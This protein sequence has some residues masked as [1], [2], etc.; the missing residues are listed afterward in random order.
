[1]RPSITRARPG[2]GLL[3]HHVRVAVGHRRPDRQPAEPGSRPVRAVGG[4]LPAHRGGVLIVIFLT[5][6]GRR[7][8]S[9]G[10]R[11]PASP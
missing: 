5:V 2:T 11:G 8:P 10:P 1:M 4:R 7:W 3:Y 6:T 9:A